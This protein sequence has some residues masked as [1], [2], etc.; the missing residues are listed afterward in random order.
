MQS[1]SFTISY[2]CWLACEVATYDDF[3]WAPPSMLKKRA[4][5]DIPWRYYLATE[6]RFEAGVVRPAPDGDGSKPPFGPLHIVTAAQPDA[7]LD[8]GE[9]CA[10]LEVLDLELARRGI[11]SIGVVG[12]SIDGTHS[13]E[14]RAISGLTD[15]EA[16]RLGARFGQVAIFR[17]LGPN[18]SVLAC[19]TQRTSHSRW[20]WERY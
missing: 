19:Q 8:R 3:E 6:V 10:R 2:G 17:W 20:T 13:E 16:R 12:S 14:S 4:S 5:T 18:W 15:D 7:E 9:I 1:N 11:P